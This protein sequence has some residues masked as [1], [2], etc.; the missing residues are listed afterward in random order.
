L[1]DFYVDLPEGGKAFKYSKQLR[2]LANREQVSLC[3]DL[4]DLASM[5]QELADACIE[6]SKRYN[7]LF[8]ESIHELLPEY[9]DKEVTSFSIFLIINFFFQYYCVVCFF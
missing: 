8:Y 2:C 4:N 6:N 1:T 9:K 3:I 5:D 7:E